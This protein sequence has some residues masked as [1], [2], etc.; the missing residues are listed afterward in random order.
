[1]I[2]L[3]AVLLFIVYAAP[4]LLTL[5]STLYGLTTLAHFF[6]FLIAVILFVVMGRS[7]RKRHRPRFANGLMIGAGVSL[8][9]T[10]VGQAIRRTPMAEEA[11]LAQVP[12]V[13][14]SAAVTML[15]LHATA[16]AILS[17][18]IFAVLFG[19]LGGIAVWWGGRRRM[20][21][22]TADPVEK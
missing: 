3:Y 13:P 1:M 12:R 6:S 21:A 2:W 10:G 9:G 14:R 15:H 4:T 18:I 7:L 17:G 5:S 8:L 11:F 22:P 19:L 20:A 16:N